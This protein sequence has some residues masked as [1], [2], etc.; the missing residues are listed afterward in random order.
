MW[1][2]GRLSIAFALAVAASLCAC[3]DDPE[4][5]PEVPANEYCDS[6]ADWD[7]GHAAF[8]REVLE[9]VN[10]QRAQGGKCGGDEE[11]SPSGAL[12]MN[13]ALRCAARKHTADMIARDYF[14]FEDPDGQGFAERAELAG[15]DAEPVG[16]VIAAGPREPAQVVATWMSNDGNCAVL[17]NP[18]QNELG[19][20]YL[21][22]EDSTYSHYWTQVFGYR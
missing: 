4:P 9:L 17:M 15:Y 7:P 18:E 6:V 3:T 5:G 14:D 8:E 22:A 19:V 20:G 1:G 11:F 21:P 10:E 12:I 16:Q 2:M 13:P